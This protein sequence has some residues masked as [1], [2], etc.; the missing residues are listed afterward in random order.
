MQEEKVFKLCVPK[1][2]VFGAF[3]LICITIPHALGLSFARYGIDY[4][5]RHY[6]SSEF[7]ATL[8]YGIGVFYFIGW[9][10]TTFLVLNILLAVL[11][12]RTHIWKFTSLFFVSIV[13][14]LTGA[15]YTRENFQ[16]PTYVVYHRQS[17]KI[18]SLNVGII[19]VIAATCIFITF[20]VL[21]L[22]L[23]RKFEILAIL[24]NKSSVVV[25]F[26]ILCILMCIV[27]IEFNILELM[28]GISR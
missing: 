6:S 17:Y 14:F 16:N 26:C 27:V 10:S 1:S 5:N 19:S 25:I 7:L 11:Y 13:Q 20:Y 23:K 21:M 15:A 2:V 3:A 22:I 4:N 9:I 18:N 8:D 12:S 24:F 28:G